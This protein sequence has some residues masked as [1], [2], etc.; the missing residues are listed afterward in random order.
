MDTFKQ[1]CEDMS[2]PHGEGGSTIRGPW[3]FY[4][5]LIAMFKEDPW[6]FT[7]V[8]YNRL[9]GA[10]PS[11]ISSITLYRPEDP[12]MSRVE[13]DYAYVSIFTPHPAT[14]E[15][16]NDNTDEDP[17]DPWDTNLVK[18]WIRTMTPQNNPIM[19]IEFIPFE[20]TIHNE[21]IPFQHSPPQALETVVHKIHMIPVRKYR[22]YYDVWQRTKGTNLDKIMALAKD[23]GLGRNEILKLKQRYGILS[24][25]EIGD[26]DMLGLM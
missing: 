2:S 16:V 6:N 4:H 1:Y 3:E 17:D 5:K 10:R 26:E 15:G 18:Y 23:V 13:L 14:P 11:E 19:E 21:S 8:K 22:R 7:H 12:E 9:S 24:H 20:Q 25:E